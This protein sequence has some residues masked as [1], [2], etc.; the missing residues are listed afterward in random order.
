[1]IDRINLARSLKKSGYNCCESVVLAYKDVLDLDE[2]T[3][4]SLSLPFGTGI[5]AST[6][7]TCGA[8]VGAV[9]VLGLLSKDNNKSKVNADARFII[10]SFKERNKSTICFELKGIETKVVLRECIDCVADAVEFLEERL[11]IM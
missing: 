11:N 1:M 7:G 5:G 9:M 8:I 4:K 6:K 10:I 3:L 2:E